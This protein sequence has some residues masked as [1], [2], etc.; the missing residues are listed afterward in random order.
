MK[1]PFT[2]HDSRFTI[3]EK[4][5]GTVCPL[6]AD[7]AHGVTHPTALNRQSSIVN[8]KSQKGV[9]LV[10]TLILLSV[11]LVMALAFLAIS[12]RERDSVVTQTDTTA[13]RLAAGAGLAAAEAQMAANILSTTDPYNFGLLVSANY[14]N[15]NGFQSGVASYKN[16]NY[17]YPNGK[18]VGGADFNQL[19]ANL[20]YSPRAPVLIST[21]EPTGRFYLDLNRNGRDE[22]NGWVSDSA[23]SNFVFAVG[24]P[25]W[26]GVLERPNLPYGPDNKFIA[27]FAFIALPVGNSL[28]LN[29]IHN[30]ALAPFLNRQLDPV[31]GDYYA[32]NQG[33]GSWELNLAAF[34]A[35][36]NT[37]EWNQYN[38]LQPQKDTFGNLI[39][40]NGPNTGNAFEDAF[41]LLTNRYA[42][43]Y[44]TLAPVGG[45]SPRGLFTNGNAFP[46]FQNNIDAYSTGPLQTTPTGI[47]ANPNVTWP[48]VGAD[49][50]NHS[51]TPGELFNPAKSSTGFA[52]RL[53]SAGTNNST[54][55]RYTFYRLLAQLGTDSAPESGK[56]NLNYNNLDPYIYV[57][58][59]NQVVNPPSSTNFI[60]WTPLGFFTNA[61]DR[62]LKAY[63]AQWATT[64][65]KDAN[66][67]LVPAPNL[68]FLAT[69]N[70][71]NAF[72]VTAIPVL[73]SNRFVYT[74]AVNRLLQLAANM[75]DATTTSNYPGFSPGGRF[76]QVANS[77]NY[78]DIY[79]PVFT[80]FPTNGYNDV[81]I[82]DYT[83]Q[84]PF[85][86]HDNQMGEIAPPVDATALAPSGLLAAA[87]TYTN[88]NVYGVPWVIG[89][90]K[91]FPNF[92]AFSVE[93]AFQLV[94]KLEV[95]RDTNSAVQPDITWTNQMYLMNIT[96]YLALSC[97]NS[98]YSNYP[99]PVDILVRCSSS[100]MLTN[101]Y[102]LNPPFTNGTSFAFAKEFS[103]WPGWGGVPTPKT[104][105]ASFVVP[106]DASVMTLTNA[107]YVYTG[108]YAGALLAAGENPGN[109]LDKGIRPLPHFWLM[110]TNRLQVA[111]ID[112]S[113]N[114]SPANASGPVVGRIVDYVQLG[115]M[116]S[117]QDLTSAI[118][119]EANDPYH[120]FD[121]TYTNG[122]LLGVL[123]QILMSEYGSVNGAT[124]TGAGAWATGQIPGGP[125]GANATGP[126]AQQEFFRGFFADDGRYNS[127]G[128][129]YVN[130]QS[131]MQAPYTPM[132]FAI[133][134]TTWE[135]ND[136]LVHYLA[137][138]LAPHT[139]TP[140]IVDV[141]ANTLR[142]TTDRYQPWGLPSGDQNAFN[143]AFKDP[144][145][146]SSDD[147]DFPANKLPTVGWLGRVHRGT[148]WQTVYLKST[149]ILNWANNAVGQNGD[150]TWKTWTGDIFGFDS[151][152][153]APVEDR[154]LFDL[155]TTA[156]NDNATRG[157]L[158]VNISSNSLAAWSAVFS[159]VNVL[160]NN[161]PN[162]GN[163]PNASVPTHYQRPLPLQYPPR[164]TNLVI[165]PAGANVNNSAL[166]QIVAGIDRT[167][168]TFTNADSLVGAFEHV[169]DILATPQLTERAPFL[170]WNND[171]QK[172]N[173]ISDEMYEWLPQQAMSLLRLGSPRYVIYSY[174]Q[175]L[176][177]SPNGTYLGSA[178]LPN[179]QSAFGL[180]TNY[181]VVSEIA[182]RAVVRL[183]T[184]RTNGLVSAGT[185]GVSSAILVT[186]PR[187]V[188]E[189]Y[190]ILPPD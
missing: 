92:N 44:Y 156:V 78:P 179:G 115:G 81:Y 29:A 56:M 171:A 36:L 113:T 53:Q 24:D 59:G 74:P 105:S 142:V 98:Y 95:E 83:S 172:A 41:A 141:N 164:Y 133:Q 40:G 9:A 110:M 114:V 130:T 182:T 181:Q 62:L 100:I 88:V 11:T 91:G 80:A 20:L 136:P 108:P 27:R 158:S 65:R 43:N 121:M 72:G 109:Y 89:A 107:I 126:E 119:T 162:S 169:G 22:P 28:D 190:N 166:A 63:S 145:V 122:L 139:E 86:D 137:N 34:L 148:P 13:A 4:P 163:P 32:R 37:N 170:N 177:P 174:G 106:L 50:T 187:A 14:I 90:K 33:V 75:Y 26:I 73:I 5:G 152:N 189:S 79:R 8:H 19:M 38:Y 154:L 131:A 116:D 127:G 17:F 101:D 54:Y 147:W 48:W 46:P 159:G 184:V 52:N 118:Q 186:P 103:P 76:V 67:V 55:D 176:K 112:Y 25:E 120:F 173:G 15:T 93:T 168:A 104:Q 185:N 155:F 188:I 64:Y 31:I 16:V 165:N 60:P 150:N 94:R 134:H 128:Q 140:A 102:N 70:T 85:I 30:Q 99:G 157:Q 132:A 42:G 123:N 180:V 23:T 6:D 7:G 39:W 129:F 117:R 18:V 45:N 12:G 49:N 87:V 175:A 135:A 82:T 3:W 47:N 167:R 153:A 178:T 61:A 125:T 161:L 138:D 111:I 149:N 51:F 183:E 2:I 151:A 66:N 35:D 68:D 143:L 144:L 160:S 96:N 71:T 21:N 57:N 1:L 77:A 69:F 58:N 146:R 10:V 124:P 97:W 84:N